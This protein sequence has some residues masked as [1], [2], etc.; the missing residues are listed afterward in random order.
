MKQEIFIMTTEGKF[1]GEA[2]VVKGLAVHTEFDHLNKCFGDPRYFWWQ[3]THVGTGYKLPDHYL[4]K[5]TALKVRR[6]LLK[7][8]DWTQFNT[9]NSFPK[10]LAAKARPIIEKYRKKAA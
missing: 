1:G 9:P 3:I 4:G 10:E 6:E 7:I 8:G 5:S 2:D